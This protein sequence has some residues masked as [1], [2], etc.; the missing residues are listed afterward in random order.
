MA[1]REAAR[2][3]NGQEHSAAGR[4]RAKS[5]STSVKVRAYS[6]ILG[7]EKNGI[8]TAEVPA[9]GF[10]TEGRG[11]RG[12]LLMA[13]DAIEGLVELS[14]ESATPLPPSDAVVIASTPKRRPVIRTKSRR[15]HSS[16]RKPVK[17]RT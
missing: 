7:A 4:H 10:V 16:V 17:A 5:K 15:R 8:W 3:K 9:F 6:V 14:R 2:R 1:C 12:A 13:K 11:Q